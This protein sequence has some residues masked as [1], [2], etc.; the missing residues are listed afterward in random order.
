MANLIDSKVMRKG[1]TRQADQFAE[2][3]ADMEVV[4][5]AVQGLVPW[6]TGVQIRFAV[7]SKGGGNS[8]MIVDI[9]A[10]DFEA[11]ARAM[12][13]NNAP[14]ALKAFARAIESYADQ[15]IA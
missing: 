3:T 9:G 8:D 1:A 7:P 5:Y 14:Q 2:V 15:S 6:Q 4:A 11:L 10:G 12:A 13:L